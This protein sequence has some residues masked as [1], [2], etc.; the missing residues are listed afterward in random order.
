MNRIAAS[1][2]AVGLL[3]APVL[4]ADTTAKTPPA[5]APQVATP[6]ADANKMASAPKPTK[7]VRHHKRHVAQPAPKTAPAPA[8]K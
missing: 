3:A 7:R 8:T 4:A 1:L 2:L 6:K 5:P